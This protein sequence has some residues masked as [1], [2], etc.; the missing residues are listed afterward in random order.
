MGNSRTQFATVLLALG[1][2]AGLGFGCA[3]ATDPLPPP[4]EL[5]LVVH[6][7]AATIRL[8]PVN[9]SG[10]GTPV[11]LGSGGATPTSVAA[12]NGIALVPLGAEPAVAVV[13]LDA[14]I[15]SRTIGLPANSGATGAAIVDDSIAY[16]GNPNL[17]TITRVNYLTGDTASLAVGVT[18]QG[19]VFTRGKLFVLNGNLTAGVPAGAGW[20]SVVDPVTNRLAT[21]ID[22]IGLTPPGNPL[23]GVVAQDGLLYLMNRGPESGTTD[24]RLSLVDPVGR[25]ELGTFKGFG[26]FPGAVAT[27]GVDRLYLSSLTQGLMVFDLRN[28]QILRG[29]GS[30]VAIPDNSG[31]TVDS[32]GRIYA[33]ESGPCDGSATGQVHVLRPNLSP[34]RM[35]PVDDCPVAAIVT[36]VPPS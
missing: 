8:I 29:A 17:N 19:L 21:G 15:V 18:P 27:N 30:G 25:E 16:V 5:L 9:G 35:V 32:D 36:E 13:D 11:A 23:Q 4:T 33:L 20:I 28:R 34:L 7:T 14:G 24:G 12:L 22:S 1:L 2:A 10:A 6:R 3:D 26:H 31:V